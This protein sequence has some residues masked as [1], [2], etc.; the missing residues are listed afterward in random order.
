MG[1][2][3]LTPPEHRAIVVNAVRVPEGVDDVSVRRRLLNEYNIEIA[4]GLGILKGK[5]WRI[6]LM[7]ESSRQENVL[8]LLDALQQSLTAEG[9]TCNSGVAAAEQVFAS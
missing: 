1:I 6:G 4:G 9:H 2:E 3:M 5:I 7:G 8:R